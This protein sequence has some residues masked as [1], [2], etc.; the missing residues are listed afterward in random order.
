MSTKTVKQAL[1]AS[2]DKVG[3]TNGHASPQSQDPIVPYLHEYYVTTLGESYFKKRRENAKKELNKRLTEVQLTKLK[4]A[5]DEVAKNQVADTC[6]LV[7][8]DH[9]M[10]NV[11]IKNGA[12]YFDVATLKVRLMRD[13]KMDATEVEAIIE[14]CT[15]RRDPSQSW[16]VVEL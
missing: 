11:E 5:A 10:L 14:S 6:A 9:Y 2:L 13:Y 7:E 4:K 8:S 16:Q 3:N 15:L 1:F 12:S